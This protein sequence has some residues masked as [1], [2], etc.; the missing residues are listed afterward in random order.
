MLD[1][2]DT[3]V[4]EAKHTKGE[5]M[6]KHLERVLYEQK[7][8]N[9]LTKEQSISVRIA[10]LGATDLVRAGNLTRASLPALFDCYVLDARSSI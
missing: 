4:T 9:S 1:I 6:N 10:M 8:L 3:L 2:Y 7:T 5:K